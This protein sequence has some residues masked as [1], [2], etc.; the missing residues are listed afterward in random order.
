MESR[1]EI[2]ICISGEAGQ[3]LQTMGGMLSAALAG[4][5]YS[6]LV[7]QTYH[8]RIRGGH[9][10]YAIR[11][12]GERPLA[13]R[14]GIDLL[15]ALNEESVTLHHGELVEGGL[16]LVDSG[17][18]SA[19][20]QRLAI[21]FTELAGKKMENTVALGITAALIGLDLQPLAELVDQE[22]AGKDDE[23]AAKNREALAKG[24]AWAEANRPRDFAPLFKS[25][26]KSGRML[27]T[28]NDAIALGALS[29]GLKFCAFYPMTPATSI[30]LGIIDQ[31]EP[32]GVV[33]EQAEDEI[34]AVN[35]AIGASFA[36]A[37]A[38][39]ATSGG[40]FALMSEG[41]SLA[42]MTEIPLL[43][44]IAQR[45]GPATGLPTRS[46]QGDLEFVLHAGHGEF[47]RAVLAPTTVEECF[48]L[49]QQAMHL[50]EK[51]QGPV[52]LLTDQ[53]FADSLQ[54]IDRDSLPQANPVQ[55]GSREESNGDGYARYRFTENG[56]SPRHLPGQGMGLVA[57]D[58][59]EHDEQGHI[60]EDL[61]IRVKMADKR[62]AK[63]ALLDQETIPPIYEGDEAADL[64]FLCWG[65]TRGAAVEAADILRQQGQSTAVLSFS[66]VW[67]LVAE[68]FLPR[69]RQAKRVVA[70]EGNAHGQFRRLIRRETGFLAD[71]LIGRYD[72]LAFDADYIIEHLNRLT[73]QGG[74]HEQH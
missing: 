16:L 11:C 45:P 20:V 35:M 36:G 44:I 51:S 58:S 72:G 63:Q 24:Y 23:M 53:Y 14:K 34:S 6:I 52:F 43:L 1:Q 17:T 59:D 70:V 38:L 48:L 13:P 33:C 46:E 61:A 2:N 9:N 21:P 28:G 30:I 47:P 68:Q 26:A 25:E 10:T 57:A 67:P 56:L 27:L 62:F 18:E 42:A 41:V 32:M 71:S 73:P 3:G 74:P 19:A 39:V 4:N 12:G 60:T 64:L 69:L 37:P 40:G 65:T 5:G 15:V 29:A 49:S 8:S 50:A 31:A 22:F 54:T 7:S 55:A 66:Q